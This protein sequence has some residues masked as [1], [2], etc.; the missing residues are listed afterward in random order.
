MFGLIEMVNKRFLEI[1]ERWKNEEVPSE[2]EKPAT[3]K[4]RN[5]RIPNFDYFFL[6][7]DLG[8]EVHEAI[9]RKYNADH[10][11][12]TSNVFYDEDDN[13]IKGSKPGYVVAV[14]EFLRDRNLRTANSYDMQKAIEE[15]TLNFNGFYEDLSLVIYSEEGETGYLARNL[16]NQIRQ[17]NGKVEFPTLIQLSGLELKTDQ[18]APQGLSFKLTDKSQTIIAPQLSHENHHKK[19]SKVDENGLPIFEENGHHTFHAGG[20][21]LR[22]LV[23]VGNSDLNSLHGDLVYSSDKGRVVICRESTCIDLGGNN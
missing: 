21:G 20:Y 19:F 13:L 3:E 11:F 10:P 9:V 2:R 5:T 18:N 7:E 15:G 8:K 23:S 14:N 4:R 1:A 12:V 16:A 22:M 17:R 6:G